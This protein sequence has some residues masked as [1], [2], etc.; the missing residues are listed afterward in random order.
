M[1][2]ISNVFEV[3]NTFSYC[4]AVQNKQSLAYVYLW[5]GLSS[6]SVSKAA[7]TYIRS[8]QINKEC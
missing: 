3:I 6:D 4:A 8:K 1:A 2:H 5:L 7:G